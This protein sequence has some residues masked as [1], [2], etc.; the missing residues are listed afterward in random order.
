M[1]LDPEAESFW[2]S[3]GAKTNGGSQPAPSASELGLSAGSEAIKE[4]NG[5]LRDRGSGGGASKGLY[6]AAYP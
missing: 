2:A 3:S 5:G 4:L 6:C 1:D